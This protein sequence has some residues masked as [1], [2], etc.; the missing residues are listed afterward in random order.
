MP[1]PSSAMSRTVAYLV[2]IELLGL[3][4]FIEVS[5]HLEQMPARYIP[6]LLALGM[7]SAVAYLKARTFSYR[8][9]AYIA[10]IVSV[11][12]VAAVQVLGFT[13]YPGLAKGIDLIS[14]WNLSH[15]LELL[16]L[17]FLGHCMLFGLTRSFT[18]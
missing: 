14:Y 17:G 18:S 16:V 15:S 1:S 5:C 4:G 6:L 11:I 12:S 13:V 9:I 3:L 7:V 10:V 8:E 2:T